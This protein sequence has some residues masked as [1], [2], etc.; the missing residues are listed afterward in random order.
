[1][2][3]IEKEQYKAIPL[4]I[5]KNVADFCEKNQLRYSLAFGTMIGAIR[6]KGF[7]PWD[8]DIDIMMPRED[9]EKFLDGYQSEYYSIAEYRKDKSY[10]FP[11]A[12]VF[13]KRTTIFLLD[14]NIKRRYGLFIDIFPVDFLPEDEQN[15]R[16]LLKKI[17]RL[18]LYRFYRDIRI[19]YYRGEKHGFIKSLLLAII[20]LCPITL[21]RAVAK[22]DK[23]A[24]SCSYSP[25]S[26]FT[27]CAEY[28]HSIPIMNTSDFD[29]MIKVEFEGFLFNCISD[30][31]NHLRQGYGDYLQ[32]PPISQRV[33]PHSLVCY[34]K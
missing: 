8:D 2:K 19:D 33:S 32:L 1:M 18:G 24:K 6:H 22:M 34:F 28:Y 10:P 4:S 27:V 26:S 16:V 30:Y 5:L 9:Y 29:N 11:F 12:K 14:R 7:I 31:D 25:I 21:H 17:K 3:E 15:R 20:K 13:D 23:Y